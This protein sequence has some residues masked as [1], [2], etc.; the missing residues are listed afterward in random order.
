MR[1]SSKALES[2]KVLGSVSVLRLGDDAPGIDPGKAGERGGNAS[3]DDP[4]L[5]G[6]IGSEG[7]PH[8]ALIALA[9]EFHV[10]AMVDPLTATKVNANRRGVLQP[11]PALTKLLEDANLPAK[12]LLQ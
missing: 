11:D 6:R 10:V 7:R 9:Q 1:R 5:F 12:P 8:V 2:F 3:P 4:D